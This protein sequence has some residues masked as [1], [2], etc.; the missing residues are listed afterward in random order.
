[1]TAKEISGKLDISLKEALAHLVSLVGEGRIGFDPSE[2][3]HYPRYV[4]SI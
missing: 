1:M 4:K 3:S 2:E